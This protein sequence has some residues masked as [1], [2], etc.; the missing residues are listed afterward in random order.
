MNVTITFLKKCLVKV[1]RLLN[2][3]NPSGQIFEWYGKVASLRSGDLCQSTP[4]ENLNI[5]LKIVVY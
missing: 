3:M 5:K 1:V 2:I 4:T